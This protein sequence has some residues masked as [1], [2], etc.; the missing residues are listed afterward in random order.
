LQYIEYK[1]EDSEKSKFLKV[2][3]FIESQIEQIKEESGPKYPIH[4][5]LIL[6]GEKF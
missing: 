4:R 2:I 6:K 5:F 3:V 1:L